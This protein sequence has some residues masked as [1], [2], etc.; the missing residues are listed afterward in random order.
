MECELF[1]V[2][3]SMPSIP[4][5]RNSAGKAQ[6]GV[7]V[8]RAKSYHGA[9]MEGSEKFLSSPERFIFSTCKQGGSGPCERVC[10]PERQ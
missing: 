1:D 7:S 5:Y 3:G 8:K 4:V 6:R 10:S 9:E 2:M